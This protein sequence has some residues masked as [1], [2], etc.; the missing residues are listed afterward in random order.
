M[1]FLWPGRRVVT[2]CRR[3]GT[4]TQPR[5]SIFIGGT[6]DWRQES[7]P[8]NALIN[9]HLKNLFRRLKFPSIHQPKHPRENSSNDRQIRRIENSIASPYN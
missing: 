4:A 1:S 6:D 2:P 3:D 7:A 5:Q 8:R 9:L